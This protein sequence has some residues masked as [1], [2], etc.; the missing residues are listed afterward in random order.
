[1]ELSII[2]PVYNVEK[3]VRPCIESIL[4]QGLD[5]ARYEVIIVNDGS[6]D[7]SMNVI[8]DLVEGHSNMNVINQS[9]QGLSVARNKGLEKAQGSYILFLDSD[10]LL[11]DYT[12]A[13]LLEEA[14]KEQ[15]DMLTA[16][17]VKM[18]DKEIEQHWPLPSHSTFRATTGTELFLHDLDPRAC[19]VWRALYK[20]DFLRQYQLQFIPGIYFEDIPFTTACYLHAGHCIK[21]DSLFYIFRQRPQSI[22]TSIDIQKIFDMNTVVA[23]LDDMKESKPVLTEVQRRQIDEIMFSTFSIIIW[24]IINSKELFAHRKEIVSDLLE[25]TRDLQFSNSLKQRMVTFLF[26]TVPCTYLSLR[27][28]NSLV[29]KCFK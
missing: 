11:L 24:Y 14:M 19:F 3:Y 1:M 18:N 4:R 9:N 28:I 17:F 12:L 21:S 5:E 2:V 25:K 29:T 16:N 6:T 22:S 13:A 23:L 26:R 8:S 20:R 15:P 27:R 7:Q 10:D